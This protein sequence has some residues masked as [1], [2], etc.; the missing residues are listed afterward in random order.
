VTAST[1]YDSETGESG[2]FLDGLLQIRE[3]LEWMGS[4]P[5]AVHTGSREIPDHLEQRIQSDLGLTPMV[6]PS[7][8]L[9]ERD[10]AGRIKVCNSRTG[11]VVLRLTDAEVIKLFSRNS[12][13]GADDAA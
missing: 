11:D 7:V 12:N 10:E 2:C 8:C 3:A 1:Y 6:R 5:A 4:H 13:I 9:N